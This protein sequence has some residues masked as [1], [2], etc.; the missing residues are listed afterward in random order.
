MVE[1]RCSS[2]RVIVDEDAV[3]VSRRIK[4]ESEQCDC[5]SVRLL[6]ILKKR[7]QNHL[8]DTLDTQ[9]SGF[10]FLKTGQC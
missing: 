6:V 1:F 10:Y 2:S 5:L 8:T 7:K 3:Q 4:I 9:K